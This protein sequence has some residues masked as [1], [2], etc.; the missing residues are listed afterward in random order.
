MTIKVVYANKAILFSGPPIDKNKDK[1]IVQEIMGTHG[2]RIVCGGTA[3][4]IVSREIGAEVK[5]SFRI[6]DRDVPPIGYID[7]IDLVTEGVLTLKKTI[8]KLRK[9][10]L[11][12]EL[13]F[14]YKEDGASQLAK[15]LYED[16]TH[17]KMIIGRAI[18]PAHQNPDFPNELSIKLYLLNELRN[19]LIELGK[20]V[21]VEYY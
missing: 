3:A 13:N 10:K 16:C 5:T 15:I 18:N 9:I 11:S 4:N 21:E 19:I 1:E 14:I 12:N 7:K 20:I 6:I 8:E 17:I 2:K